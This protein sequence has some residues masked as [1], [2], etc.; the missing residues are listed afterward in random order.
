[1]SGVSGVLRR[2]TLNKTK[3]IIEKMGKAMANWEFCKKG[4]V[5][6]LRVP[7]KAMH[8]REVHNVLQTLQSSIDS[9][10]GECLRKN[11]PSREEGQGLYL[12]LRKYILRFDLP[13]EVT[14]RN[15]KDGT[16]QVFICSITTQEALERKE[17][18]NW[19]R[20][21]RQAKAQNPPTKNKSR[22]REVSRRP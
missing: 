12:Y 18:M 20:Q 15:N 14:Y 22:T 16:Y 17:F 11:F 2:H 3:K 7:R 8:L 21:R 6:P 4:D 10:K 19:R 13:F 1:M 9:G 5:P